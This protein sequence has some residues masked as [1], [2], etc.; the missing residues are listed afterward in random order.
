MNEFGER[1]RRPSSVSE[2][3]ECVRWANSVSDRF[4]SSGQYP[5]SAIIAWPKKLNPSLAWHD[6]FSFSTF[7]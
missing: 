7:F 1:V 2:F 6:Y 4:F 5:K 3:G